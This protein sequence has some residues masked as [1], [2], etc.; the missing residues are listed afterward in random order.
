MRNFLFGFNFEK[1]TM[2]GYITNFLVEHQ[3]DF[4]CTMPGVFV[5]DL[6]STNEYYK[7]EIED[8]VNDR[9]EVYYDSSKIY[10]PCGL[11]RR[12]PLKEKAIITHN[13]T[14]E[15][16]VYLE[17]DDTFTTR[18]N[19]CKKYIYNEYMKRTFNM[20]TVEDN[21]QRVAWVEILA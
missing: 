8:V 5:A 15:I 11:E 21:L 20:G 13:P 4:Y 1:G 3:I 6:F 17:N 12:F 16:K 9:K 2:N 7:L 14:Y 18:I 10:Q 19:A